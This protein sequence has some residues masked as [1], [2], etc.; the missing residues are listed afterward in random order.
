[1]IDTHSH[2]DGIEFS[3][4]LDSV[5]SRAKQAG[6]EKVLVPAISG[7]GLPRLF[8]VCVQYTGYLYPMIGLHP[9]E[10]RPDKKDVNRELDRMEALLLS[11]SVRPAPVAIGEIGLDF[12]WDD[13]FRAEQLSAFDRQLDWAEKF[14]LPVMIHARKAHNELLECVKRHRPNQ[15]RGVFHCFTGSPEMARQLLAFPG[16]MLGIGGVVTF[17]NAKLP[18]TLAESVPL[19][20]IVM[21]TDAPYMSPVPHRG[22]R[23]EP[24]FVTLVAE[25]LSA[26][27]GVD[28]A[29]VERQTN[30]NVHRIFGDI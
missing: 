28:F 14:H 23:N 11:H 8:E 21:E 30:E 27:Y 15:L 16:F 4:D 2:I 17:K 12:Y 22:E 18:Q 29:E 20:R 6:I 13:T 25:K 26:I 9:E 7:E 1:M 10:V 5:V 19:D 24:A 3:E